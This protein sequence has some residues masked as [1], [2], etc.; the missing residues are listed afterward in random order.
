MLY[1][2]TNIIM[3]KSQNR[4][5]RID[6]E[7]RLI[8]IFENQ[9]K[10]TLGW[11]IAEHVRVN[12]D[13]GAVTFVEAVLSSTGFP[14][15]YGFGAEYEELDLLRCAYASEILAIRLEHCDDPEAP[16]F[17]GEYLGDRV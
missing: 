16:S 1:L 3:S 15:V 14:S 10:N 4:P 12:W 6:L 5:S 11:E 9:Q 13:E 7:S 2:Q 17:S 8:Q